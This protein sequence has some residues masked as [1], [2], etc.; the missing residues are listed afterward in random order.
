MFA[1]VLVRSHKQIN[2]QKSIGN[3]NWKNCATSFEWEKKIEKSEEKKRIQVV[4]KEDKWQCTK[5][6]Q[7]HTRARAYNGWRSWILFEKKGGKN[8]QKIRENW[9]KLHL[10]SRSTCKASGMLYS[11]AIISFLHYF[12]FL[13]IKCNNNSNKT[14]KNE[15]QFKWI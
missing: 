8:N 12:G 1:C 10:H 15:M 4:T 7:T 14:K 5:I 2:G 13:H 6:W 11:L 9:R 3:S